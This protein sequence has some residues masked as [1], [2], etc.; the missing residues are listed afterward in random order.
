[1]SEFEF[2]TGWSARK[3]HLARGGYMLCGQGIPVRP[4][5]SYVGMYKAAMTQERI[6]EMDLCKICAR[7][8]A[9]HGVGEQ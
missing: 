8:A 7:A 1:V 5:G 9:F 2:V 4:G 3:R 6:D